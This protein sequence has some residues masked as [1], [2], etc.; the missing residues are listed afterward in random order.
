MCSLTSGRSSV[1]PSPPRSA[2]PIVSDPGGLRV[3]ITSSKTLKTWAQAVTLFVPSIPGL[4]YCPMAA[5]YRALRQLPAIPN[6]PAFLARP[7][8]LLTTRELTL[9]LREALPHESRYTLHGRWWGSRVH[10][11]HG[12]LGGD[13]SLGAVFWLGLG[14]LLGRLPAGPQ[15]APLGH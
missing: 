12:P 11:P 14:H 3:T 10:A 2:S 6:A 5:W 8:V 15:V 1:S 7:G 4:P 9:T 13:P